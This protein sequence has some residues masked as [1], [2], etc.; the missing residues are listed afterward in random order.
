MRNKKDFIKLFDLNVPHLDHFD[1]YISQ[2]HKTKKYKNIYSLI[3]LFE[4]LE[5]NIGDIQEFKYSKSTKLIDLLKN[6]QAYQNMCDDKDLI[7][8]PTNKTF[9][10]KEGVKYLSIDI[11]SAN[12]NSF[13]KYDSINEL[14]DT[15][16]DFLLKFDLSEIFSFSKN[17]RQFIFGNVNPKRQQKVQR[18]IIQSIV[19]DLSD[20]LSI[21]CVKNDEVIFKFDDDYSILDKIDQSKFKCKIFTCQKIDNFT[22]NTIYDRNGDIIDKEMVGVPG[23]Q[24]YMKLKQHILNEDL[25]IKDLY[26]K[27]DGNLAIWSVDNLN[28]S[29]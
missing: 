5:S 15:Y 21:E 8:L 28:I 3:D 14:G 19:R 20:D 24:F 27:M 13:K 23:N 7:D 4:K 2:L 25:D 18:N 17:L 26:F 16:K 1:Y 12:W 22:I 11:I 6:S 29:L 9:E 10:Y